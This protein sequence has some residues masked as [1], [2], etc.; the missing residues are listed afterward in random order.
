MRKKIG[1]LAI[2]C[3]F[4]LSLVFVGVLTTQEPVAGPPR[5]G[6]YTFFPRPQAHRGGVDTNL[7]LHKIVVRSGYFTMFFTGSPVGSGGDGNYHGIW[8]NQRLTN[9][10]TIIRQQLSMRSFLANQIDK[11]K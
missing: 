10:E 8:N 1:L 3:F 9:Q 7:Y 6:T 5:N 2:V 4:V 11:N